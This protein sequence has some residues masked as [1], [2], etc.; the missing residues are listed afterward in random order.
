MQIVN[1]IHATS[2][3]WCQNGEESCI[4]LSVHKREFT[5]EREAIKID[6]CLSVAKH[7]YAPDP[8]MVF[9][10]DT[11]DCS[12]SEDDRR[13]VMPKF[14]PMFTR[15]VFTRE[16]FTSGK[17]NWSIKFGRVIEFD[18]QIQPYIG[19]VPSNQTSFYGDTH[20]SANRR[21]QN[22]PGFGET[23]SASNEPKGST[24]YRSLGYFLGVGDGHFYPG[25]D[26]DDDEE[27]E[28][29]E[30]ISLDSTVTVHL[31]MDAKTIAYSVNGRFLGIAYD[32]LPEGPLHPA[33]A[34]TS[35]HFAE[36][37]GNPIR[38]ERSS[39]HSH[40]HSAAWGSD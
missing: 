3:A 22:S 19:V 14:D 30:P 17:H 20:S 13:V 9:V 2:S 23:K 16:G 10:S 12:F 27:I 37:V 28:Y 34:I 6:R 36:F 24:I 7:W 25:V 26:I 32:D 29:T 4:V 11:P 31:D 40:S 39:Q 35:G 18:R 5:L 8:A 33:V 38:M 21:G 1:V 15:R